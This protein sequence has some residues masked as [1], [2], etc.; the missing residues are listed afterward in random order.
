[1]SRELR[2]VPLDFDWPL[3]KVWGG[4]INPNYKPCP[5]TETLMCSGG[6][7]P[8]QR[9]L[10]AIVRLI[11]I[12]GEE[13]AAAPHAEQLKAMGRSYPHPWLE[14]WN[15]AAREPR[16]T[17]P[18]LDAPEGDETEGERVTRMR[19]LF[20]H[21]QENTPRLL[22]LTAEMVQFVEGLAKAKMDGG[23]HSINFDIYKALLKAAGIKKNSGW[24]I[25]TVCK[26]SGVDPAVKDAYDA[27]K[28]TPVPK[29]DGY[30]LWSTVSDGAP[31]SKVY[32]TREEFVAHLIGEGYT[33]RAAEQFTK[34]G[35]TPSG[36]IHVSDEGKATG[37]SDIAACDIRSEE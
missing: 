36:L 34:T 28:E 15:M 16:K 18:H 20:E 1:M 27:W 26:G 37:Y 22:P 2:R 21:Y 24:G 30:Q 4:F 29:G 35:W 19:Q 13:A 14:E 3:K 12:V 7:T 25:C 17:P 32:A 10:E 23:L 31:V 6:Y 9:W 11:A 8:A 5:A 33:P